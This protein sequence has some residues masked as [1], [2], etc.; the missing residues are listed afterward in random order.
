MT[1]TGAAPPL[2]TGTQFYLVRINVANLEKTLGWYQEKLG[3]TCVNQ[4][5]F[6]Q[7]KV[8]FAQVQA[9]N[10]LT[11]EFLEIEDSDPSP[12]AHGGLLDTGRVQGIVHVAFLVDDCDAAVDEL[13]RRGVEMIEGAH[14]VSA[15]HVRHAFF[16]DLDGNVLE[17]AQPLS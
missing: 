8:R 13:N 4:W 14:D 17:L 7:H 15:A 11:I 12:I 3:W 2:G 9:P 16:H 10:G 5:G 1:A 6:P